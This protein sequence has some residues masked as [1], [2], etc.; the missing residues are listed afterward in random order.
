MRILCFQHRRV[1]VIE[2]GGIRSVGNQQL[3]LTVTLLIS[4]VFIDD[5][6]QQGSD[7]NGAGDNGSNDQPDTFKFIQQ[8]LI[9]RTSGM[10]IYPI[11]QQYKKI[12]A[13]RKM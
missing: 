1:G 11:R 7:H 3:M 9:V 2:L 12:K 5:H 6:D 4:S 13:L 10:W 8:Q